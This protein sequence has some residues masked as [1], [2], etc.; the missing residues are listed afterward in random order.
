M[1][2]RIDEDVYLAVKQ[3]TLREKVTMRNFTQAALRAYL[4]GKKRGG[5]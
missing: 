5:K 4:A 1:L 2:V 3:W